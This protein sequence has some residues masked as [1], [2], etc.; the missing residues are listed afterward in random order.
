MGERLGDQAKGMR[1]THRD[2]L[3]K[4]FPGM[5]NEITKMVASGDLM[6]IKKKMKDIENGGKRTNNE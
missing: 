6:G 4:E 1:K 5:L 2:E 3:E